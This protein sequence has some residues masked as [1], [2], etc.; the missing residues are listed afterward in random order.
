VVLDKDGSPM[1]N[2][3]G[4]VDAGRISLDTTHS[5]QN[6]KMVAP[7][8]AAR[9]YMNRNWFLSDPD[10]FNVGENVPAPRRR[11]GTQTR[12][13]F[14]LQEAQA[15]I[16]L[17][18]IS[19][20]MYELGDDLPSL[21]AEKERLALVENQE[22]LQMA[23]LS[24]SFKPLDLL[25]YEPE[26]EVPAIYFLKEDQRQSVLA[27]YNWTEKPRSHTLKFADLGLPAG[28]A[29]QATDVLN[30][31]APVSL[32]RAEVRVLDQPP[33]SVKVIKLIDSTV[34]A[35]APK[36]K[37]QVPSEASLAMPLKL[38]AQAEPDGVPALA[39]HWDF[40]DGT[41]ADGPEVSHTYTRNSDFTVRLT[42]EGLDGLPALQSFPVKVSGTVPQPDVSKNPRYVEPSGR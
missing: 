39:Y 8:I 7:G 29:F 30:Q 21:G 5:F 40:G 38:S 31:G 22:L 27:V 15:A 17:S 42:V 12:P 4:I 6:A 20:G 37:G 2:P 9:F 16:M 3:V 35:A 10:A 23:K 36:I 14:T 41:A 32:D 13:G 18:V 24:R 33:H 28:H 19:G 11:P 25:S 1:L 34:P 26:D